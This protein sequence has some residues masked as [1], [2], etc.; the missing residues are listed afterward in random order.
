M[1]TRAIVIMM[2]FV[3]AGFV[4]PCLADFQ[5]VGVY[6][7]CD[8]PW[9]NN[10]DQD[11]AYVSATGG[12]TSANVLVLADIQ[13]ATILAAFNAGMGGVVDFEGV[14]DALD[15]LST[16]HAIY[17]VGGTAKTL[18]IT[19]SGGNGMS[20][21]D[22]GSGGRYPTSGNAN[23]VKNA[24]P[25]GFLLRIDGIINGDGD[26]VVKF[27]GTL[28]SREEKG[29]ITANVTATFSDGS[30]V[31]STASCGGNGIAADEDTF[32]GFVAPAG[33][34]ITRVDFVANTWLY[35]DDIFF[36][37]ES[38]FPPAVNAGSDQSDL[39]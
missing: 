18:D 32:F 30:T 34:Y 9:Y 8:L 12:A 3:V 4:I 16:I 29:A 7:P 20:W 19:D 39:R 35:L 24:N 11:G 33:A 26:A 23:M 28:V 27:G 21:A 14:G 38:G 37:T 2:M 13:G 1:K 22:D 31:T 10:I 17:N 15:G 6:D 36:I 5:T 25:P